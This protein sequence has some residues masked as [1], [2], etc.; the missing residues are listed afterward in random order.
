M[1]SLTYVPKCIAGHGAPAIHIKRKELTRF[2]RETKPKNLTTARLLGGLL[3][4]LY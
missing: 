1:A 2:I 3:A 4:K